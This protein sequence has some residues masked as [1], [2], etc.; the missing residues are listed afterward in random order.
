[1]PTSARRHRSLRAVCFLAALALVASAVPAVA[2]PRTIAAGGVAAAV[3]APQDTT[4]TAAPL[5]MGSAW[6]SSLTSQLRSL[7]PT[8]TQGGDQ[9][10]F[11]LDVDQT[12]FDSA[13]SYIIEARNVLGW[14]PDPVVEVYGPGDDFS[15][16]DYST[17]ASDTARLTDFALGTPGCV[18]AN[19][20]AAWM[21]GGKASV[22]FVPPAPGRYYVRVRSR[23]MSLGSTS[24]PYRISAKNGQTTRLSGS[25]A[26][27]MAIAIS[28]E[29]YP[30]G[31]LKGHTV[32]LAST[33]YPAAALA[34]STLGGAIDAPVLFTASTYLTAATRDEIRRLGA[35]EVLLLGGRSVLGDGVT[36]GLKRYV[37][38]V[39][40]GRVL[41]GDAATI[42]M[43][44]ARSAN[45]RLVASGEPTV[46]VAFLVGAS[47][48][49]DA[50]IA[51]PMAAAD[52]APLLLTATSSLSA[53][54]LAALRDPALGIHDV[55]IVGPTT[56]VSSAVESKLRGMLGTDHVKRIGMS[57]RYREARTFALWATEPGGDGSV[58][59]SATPNALPTLEYGRVALAPGARTSDAA[60]AGVF[61][62]EAHAP[63]LLTGVT[64]L[65]PWVVDLS[66]ARASYR[67]ASDEP[68]LRS[69]VLG[70]T[71][72]ISEDVRKSFDV[73]AAGPWGE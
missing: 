69:Y 48:T 47:A 20:E 31:T 7:A 65:S 44:A 3:Y 46:G 61:A 58:G 67:S 42:A 50:L 13:Q 19:D 68:I 32:I 16:S 34:A 39:R 66:G 17:L 23:W 35:T 56:A 5:P 53:S 62:G 63:I 24:G 12:A 33:R 43:S 49:S 8:E 73:L 29:R 36:T 27:G 54:A 1:M 52:H 37:P 11:Y 64:T 38:G 40:V 6:G 55:V 21:T 72:T 2:S 4:S 59:T 45:S 14:A 9:D 10:W 30:G 60:A 15:P 26:L 57:D 22:S 51:S 18:A 28:R 41:G 71:S 70:S 25:G